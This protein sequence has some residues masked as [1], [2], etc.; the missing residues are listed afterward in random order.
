MSNNSR[1]MTN[2]QAHAKLAILADHWGFDSPFELC[3]A[4]VLDSVAP[5]ICAD[6]DCDYSTEVEPDCD[7]G[8]CECCDDQTVVS[9]LVLG[10]FI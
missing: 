1:K 8:W 6:P 7:G 9:C 10:G 3:E 5:G 4:Y 2:G